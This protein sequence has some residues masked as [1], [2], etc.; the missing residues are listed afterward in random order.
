MDQA[1]LHR[2]FKRLL[3]SADLPGFPLHELRHSAGHALYELTG[4]LVMAQKL[5]RHADIGTTRGYLHPSMDRLR[6]KLEELERLAI[7]HG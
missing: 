6:E 4:D 7:P 3:E 5:L 1:T 2:G